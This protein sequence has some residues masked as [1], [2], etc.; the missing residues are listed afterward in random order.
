MSREEREQRDLEQCPKRRRTSDAA[1][2]GEGSSRG[3]ISRAMSGEAKP[4]RPGDPGWVARARVPIPSNK[5]YVVRPKW[6]VDTDI[7]KVGQSALL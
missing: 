5:D 4:L 7:S 6:K 2:G 3:D 1:E